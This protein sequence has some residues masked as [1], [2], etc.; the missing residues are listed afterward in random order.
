[1]G[2]LGGVRVNYATNSE[3]K[4][5]WVFQ[6]VLLA[7]QQNYWKLRDFLL[8]VKLPLLF[9]VKVAVYF[10]PR[11]LK[12]SIELW[13]YLVCLDARTNHRAFGTQLDILLLPERFHVFVQ[14]FQVVVWCI[15]EPDSSAL[16]G[17]NDLAQRLSYYFWALGLP[18]ELELGRAEPSTRIAANV[19]LPAGLRVQ[20]ESGMKLNNVGLV[21]DE[22]FELH[23][24]LIG[25][26]LAWRQP[27]LQIYFLLQLFW[28]EIG[29]R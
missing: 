15:S 19:L 25:L 7:I 29:N 2:L 4:L 11:S 18:F 8:K 22:S 1:M 13:C 16:G 20:G 17:D 23:H 27:Q 12:W 3:F 5:Q 28:A 14:A 24:I 21:N 26:N 6:L 9:E 10:W